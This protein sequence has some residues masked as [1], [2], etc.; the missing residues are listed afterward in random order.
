MELN[1]IEEKKNR[2]EFEI[3]ENVG[4][5]NV[6]KKELLDDDS[7]KVATHFVKHPLVSKPR[8]IIESD[9]PRKDLINAANRLKKINAKF[10]EEVKKEIS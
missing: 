10:M 1:I 7:V 9:E 3:D 4:F 2:L 5:L 8:M 6:L